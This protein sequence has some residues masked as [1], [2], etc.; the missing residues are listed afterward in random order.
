MQQRGLPLDRIAAWMS[1]RPARLAGLACKG[2][3]APGFDADFAVFDPNA[4]W[5]VTANDLHFRHKLSPYLGAHLRGLIQETWLR[6]T[7]V[8]RDGAFPAPPHGREQVRA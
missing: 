3:L 2:A 4:A 6:G 8:F 7:C 5:T 1:E